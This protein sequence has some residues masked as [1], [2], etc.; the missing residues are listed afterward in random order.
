MKKGLFSVTFRSLEAEKIT[1]LAKE[2]ALD[3][4]VW[5]G[6]VHVP[7]GELET[8]KNAR[9]LCQNVGLGTDIY[10]SYYKLASGDFS[11]VCDTAKALGS[12]VIRIWAGT[13]G[14]ADTTDAEREALVKRLMCAADEARSRSLTLAF[15]YHGGTLTDNAESALSLVRAAE[16]DNVRLHWQPNQYR[17]FDYNVKALTLV[18]PYVDAAH[19]F[20]WRGNDKFP[21]ATQEYEW[22]TY[23]DI[24]ARHGACRDAILEFV[25]IE[26]RED[27][28]RDAQ[29]LDEML[30]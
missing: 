10:G 25:P 22:R 30:K 9:S 12:S 26:T 21:L 2:A 1:A 4:I 8:A 24:L 11:A 27:L 17:D 13:K 29:T 14:S 7:H 15:E 16:R 20:A 19:V 23:F 3:E 28:L 6:D 18:A 5:G